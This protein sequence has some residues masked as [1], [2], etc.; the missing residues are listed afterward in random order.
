[1]KNNWGRRGRKSMVGGFTIPMLSVPITPNIVS[2]HPT[3]VIQHF[4]INLV[5]DLWKIGGFFRVLR[6]SPP[7][8]LTAT[9]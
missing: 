5:S 6:F 8:K 4:V 2:S 1:M 3:Q 7:V 9:I